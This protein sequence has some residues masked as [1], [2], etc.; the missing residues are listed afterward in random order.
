MLS[1][2][3]YFWKFQEDLAMVAS[4]D[5]LMQVPT[6]S[7]QP[8]PDST[9]Q[10]ANLFTRG[11]NVRFDSS[12]FAALVRNFALRTRSATLE[13]SP[14]I[15]KI[16]G[17]PCVQTPLM[18][19]TWAPSMCR[20]RV[21]VQLTSAT[22]HRQSRPGSPLRNACALPRPTLGILTT[23]WGVCDRWEMRRVTV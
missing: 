4:L 6:S 13:K 18:I 15:S 20:R 21:V 3:S 23:V 19:G 17:V 5:S 8:L 22:V 1:L 16:D 7:R 10:A 11:T 9:V 2:V 12:A 14:H